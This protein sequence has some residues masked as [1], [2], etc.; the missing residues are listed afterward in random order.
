M[1]GFGLC[2]AAEL[3]VALELV[4]GE[5]AIAA[6]LAAAGAGLGLSTPALFASGLEALSERDAGVATG[7]VWSGRYLGSITASSLFAAA[8]GEA[9]GAAAADVAP[10]LVGAAAAAALGGLLAAR[11]PRSN[12]AKRGGVMHDAGRPS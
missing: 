3:P 7:V 11:L 12:L 5:A 10:M 6:C 8:V 1:L 4:T 9:S 2:A